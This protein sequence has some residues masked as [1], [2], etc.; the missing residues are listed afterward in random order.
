MPKHFTK[1]RYGGGVAGQQGE[2]RSTERVACA[3]GWEWQSDST[4]RGSCGGREGSAFTRSWRHATA[5]TA[6]VA[7]R[8]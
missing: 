7:G 2:R 5:A 4:K 1:S 8:E 3:G 6:F